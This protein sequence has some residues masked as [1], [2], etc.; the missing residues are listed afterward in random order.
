MKRV[1]SVVVLTDRV[2]SLFF[3]IKPVE[4]I[5]FAQFANG[6]L[7]PV[8]AIFLLWVVNKKKVMGVYRNTI[9]QN[10]LAILILILVIGL[11]VKSILKVFGIL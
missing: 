5:K 1:K 6:I 7:L 9:F 3:N 10:I 8:I 2:F 11:G 4:I